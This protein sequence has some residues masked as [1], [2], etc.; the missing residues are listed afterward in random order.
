MLGNL[1]A[2]VHLKDGAPPPGGETAHY[3]LTA[4][5]EGCVP[6]A[7]FSK[8]LSDIGYDGYLSLEWEQMW[9]PK[10]AACYESTDALLEAYHKLLERWF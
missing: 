10:L 1:I 4:L 2:H 7:E 3:R 5:D 6:F 9:H 8:A